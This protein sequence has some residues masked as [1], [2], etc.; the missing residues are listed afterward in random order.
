MN[1]VIIQDINISLNV[2]KF[3]EKFSEITITSLVN[4]FLK[5]N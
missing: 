5:Y 3:A 2:N 4:L 1:A